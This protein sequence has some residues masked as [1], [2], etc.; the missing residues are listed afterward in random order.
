MYTDFYF[1][2]PSIYTLKQII[3]YYKKRVG[4]E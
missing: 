4:R 3:I 1:E 2:T